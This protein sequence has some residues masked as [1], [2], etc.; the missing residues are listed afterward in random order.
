[1]Q[2]S[3]R[4]SL[5][6]LELILAILLFILS[7][8]ICIQVFVRSH[9]IEAKSTELNQAVYASTSIAELFRSDEDLSAALKRHYPQ[10]AHQGT[11]YQIFYDKNWNL[12]SS[13]DAAYILC[14]ETQEDL[15]FLTG[16]ISV[17]HVNEDLADIYTLPLK[18]YMW[19][20]EGI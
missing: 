20:E 15:S 5:F 1:M 8:A 9:T 16:T 3:R 4:S 19:K 17:K 6:L 10:A 18:K 12:T 14:L 11:C 2:P 13:S 7:A